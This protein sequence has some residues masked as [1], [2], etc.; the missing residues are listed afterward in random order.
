MHHPLDIG[1]GVLIGIAALSAMV[2]VSR[3]A[4][5]GSSMH[6]SASK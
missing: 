4:D 1:G 3:A 5:V 6:G 2:L